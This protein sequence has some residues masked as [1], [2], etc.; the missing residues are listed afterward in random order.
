M[1]KVAL[2]L[3]CLVAEKVQEFHMNRKPKAGEDEGKPGLK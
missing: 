3:D 2:P 1:N